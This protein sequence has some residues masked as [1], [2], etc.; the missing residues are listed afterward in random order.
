MFV[1]K[2]GSYRK[3][4]LLKFLGLRHISKNSFVLM[5]RKVWIN[6]KNENL[7]F[8][9][10][11]LYSNHGEYWYFL[12]LFFFWLVFLF[13]GGKFGFDSLFNVVFLY[14]KLV[15]FRFYIFFDLIDL[16]L[17]SFL[18]KSNIILNLILDFLNFSLPVLL[19]CF[20]LCLDSTLYPMFYSEI[21]F[22]FCVWRGIFLLFFVY[23]ICF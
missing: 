17:Y 8:F 11:F 21:L 6:V 1:E 13:F 7:I 4:F 15:N 22:C 10:L 23:L 2:I 20:S 19:S 9:N 3:L 18:P 12:K 5:S 16:F 14:L